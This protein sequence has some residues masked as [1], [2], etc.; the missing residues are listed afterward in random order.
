MFY[1]CDIHYYYQLICHFISGTKTATDNPCPAGTYSP[2]T[3]NI[4]FEQCVDCTKGHYCP[5]ASVNPTACPA[6]VWFPPFF[7][8]VVDFFFFA[9]ELGKRGKRVRD[10]GEKGFLQFRFLFYLCFFFIDFLMQ[11]FICCVVFFFLSFFISRMNL[12]N[13]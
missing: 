12:I 2:N 9:G 11:S 6:C 10:E 4:R 8:V 1:I 3:G 7:I 5:Q 13:Y